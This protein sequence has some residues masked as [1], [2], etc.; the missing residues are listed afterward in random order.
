MGRVWIHY[1]EVQGAHD[2]VILVVHECI[3]NVLMFLL[4]LS[5]IDD[6]SSLFY[7]PSRVVYIFD[8]LSEKREAELKPTTFS[9]LLL[10]PVFLSFFFFFLFPKLNLVQIIHSVTET[11]VFLHQWCYSLLHLKY[12][13]GIIT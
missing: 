6:N 13:K 2:H 12:F 8:F 4:V 11:V 7:P 9:S 5:F 3:W 10:L 1:F